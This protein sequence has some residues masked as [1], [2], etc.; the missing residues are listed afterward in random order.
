M[1][2][3]LITLIVSFLLDGIVSNFVSLNTNFFNPLFSLVAIILVYPFFNKND[4]NYLKIVSI[5][6][7]FYD[8]V[9]T[10]MMVL[11]LALFF[12]LGLL[13][14]YF[15][16]VFT[17]NIINNVIWLVIIIVFY[18]LIAY[19]ILVL[20]GYLPFDIDILFKSIYSSLI[21]NIIYC[22]FVYYFLDYLSYKFKI[23]KRG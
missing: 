14:K 16:S 3:A 4:N 22:L 21:L 12:V 11:N 20:A 9:Y 7:L 19:L 2:L 23:R 13:I 10:D 18:R 5:M 17:E 1:K 15:Y 8:F 6:G